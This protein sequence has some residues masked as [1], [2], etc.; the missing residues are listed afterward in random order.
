MAIASGGPGSSTTSSV[1][2]P[3]FGTGRDVKDPDAGKRRSR[4][5]PKDEWAVKAVPEWRIVD[6]DL[7]DA[8][9]SRQAALDARATPACDGSTFQS[10]QRGKHLFSKLL[11]CDACGGG[12][13]MVSETHLGCSNARNKG[14]AVCT[15]RRAVKREFVEATVLDALRER[16]IAPELYDSN[17]PPLALRVDL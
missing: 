12:F 14:D 5:N 6:Q 4:L 16:L 11:T 7:W 8:V 3:W 10:K 17:Y 1:S 15:N 13:S 9:R 2:A